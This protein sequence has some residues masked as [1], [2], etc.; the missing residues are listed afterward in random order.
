MCRDDVF[1][2]VWTRSNRRHM[3]CPQS[4]QTETAGWGSAQTMHC[5]TL[6]PSFWRVETSF[7]DIYKIFFFNAYRGK[8]S[9]GTK[10]EE[11]LLTLCKIKKDVFL[12]FVALYY[13]FDSR[14]CC[15]LKYIW[16]WAPLEL[17]NLFVCFRRRVGGSWGSQPMECLFCRVCVL[18]ARIPHYKSGSPFFFM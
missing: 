17:V 4:T 18:Y 5:L 3:L 8:S 1:C 15:P 10:D 14:I 12:D 16:N 2:R 11:I 9:R 6:T 7:V 13:F